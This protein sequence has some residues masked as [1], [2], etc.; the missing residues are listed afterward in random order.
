MNQI[1][2]V[3]RN[4]ADGDNTVEVNEDGNWINYKQSKFYVPDNDGFS[5]G[6][7]TFINCVK[8]NYVVEKSRNLRDY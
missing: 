8:Q 4:I 5:K 6:Y 1:R 7:L 3:L 2:W